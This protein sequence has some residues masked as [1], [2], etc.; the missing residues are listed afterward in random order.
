VRDVC[1]CGYVSEVIL[2]S[3]HFEHVSSLCSK[4]ES[5]HIIY[6]FGLSVSMKEVAS[7]HLFYILIYMNC[8]IFH[9]YFFSCI[10]LSRK[11]LLTNFYMLN[12]VIQ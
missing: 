6:L 11:N 1:V 10:F 5:K 8:Y 12:F 2:S 7:K 3:S 9:N 4:S